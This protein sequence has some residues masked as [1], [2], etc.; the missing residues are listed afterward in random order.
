MS[1]IDPIGS[2]DPDLLTDDQAAE[3]KAAEKA[4][5]AGAAERAADAKIEKEVDDDFESDEE[6][7]PQA[8]PTDGGATLP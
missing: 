4:H 8:E 2:P 7:L 6:L 5:D 3:E 1:A